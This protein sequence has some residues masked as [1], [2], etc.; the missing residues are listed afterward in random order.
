VIEIMEEVERIGEVLKLVERYEDYLFR[1]AWGMTFIVLGLLAPVSFLIILKAQP[2][3]MILG[4]STEAFISLASI[5][6]ALT[7]A[8]IITYLFASATVALSKKR[9]FSFSKDIPHALLLSLTWFISFQLTHYA[10]E[11]FA[12]VSWLWAGGFASLFS[13]LVLLKV[14]VHKGFRELLVTGL[15]LIV[16]SIPIAFIADAST[17]E[18]ASLIVFSIA[19]VG[20]GIYSILKATKVLGGEEA[21]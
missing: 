17:A 12:A 1:R 11:R 2:I 10:P 8:A 16:T 20:G 21:M 18:T 14:Q 5:T 9:K 13:Y 4:M 6:I 19:F 3:A 15:I 7:L